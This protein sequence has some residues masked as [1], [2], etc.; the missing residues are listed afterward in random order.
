M[1]TVTCIIGIAAIGWLFYL[2]WQ[3]QKRLNEFLVDAKKVA[4]NANEAVEKFKKE[5]G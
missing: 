5:H 4:E 2:D 1:E 3:T